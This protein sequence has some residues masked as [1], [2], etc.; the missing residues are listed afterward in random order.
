M[1]KK[2]KLSRV[3]RLEI[4]VL[5]DK[6]YSLREIAK[7]M[8]RG[9]NTISYE[10]KANGG[11]SGYDPINANIYAQTRKKDTRR[12]WS[13]IEHNAD[14]KTYI[15]ECLEKHWNPDEISGRMKKERKA[16]YISKTAI[17]DWLRSVYGQQYCK[18]L[19]S[20]RCYRK[21][22]VSKTEKV[23]IP[24]RIG[25]EK[26][27]CGASKRTRY[28]HWEYDTIVSRKGCSG[29]LSVGTE[30]K[31]RLVLASKV[32]SMSTFE[33]M[34]SIRNQTEKYKTLSITFDNG[35]ENKAH[36]SLGIPTFFCE[37]YSSWQ[38]GSVENANKILR[39]YFP[40]GTNFR[41]I[42]QRSVDYAVS[43]INN[44]PRKI[45]GYR[46]ALEVARACG[47]IKSESVLI[48]G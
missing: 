11:M 19:Y 5:L 48:E 36:Q 37:A 39:R 17:Y 45:L 13:K 43:L 30:R 7:S 1:A 9:H 15:I 35:L 18:Y 34:E 47:I 20:E 33:H 46:T 32:K 2:P 14:L 29:G 6:G 12:E 22:R 44:K 28:G 3:E 31:T 10:I 23:M 42:N 26:R 4:K 25:I 38:K 24:N 40:K 21:K 41:L 27:F 8:G 16:W